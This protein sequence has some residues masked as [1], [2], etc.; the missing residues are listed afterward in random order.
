MEGVIA[1]LRLEPM[2]PLPLVALV[3]GLAGGLGALYLAQ[4]IF[5]LA[6][7]N[8][9]PA[10]VKSAGAFWLVGV[11]ALPPMALAGAALAAFRPLI[12]GFLLTAAAIM[13]PALLGQNPVAGWSAGLIAAAGIAAFLGDGLTDG[14]G[15]L[16][17][18]PYWLLMILF[19]LVFTL[20]TRL[21]I[22]NE[23]F[24]F[25]GYVVLE[26]VVL[27]TAWNI[28][29]GYTGYTNFGTAAFFALGAY[30][31]VVLHK[32]PA[33]LHGFGWT[34]PPVPLPVMMLAG[35]VVSGV[36]GL[37]MG[38]LTLRLRGVFFAIATLAL[39]I[40]AQT[41]IVN[42][43]FVGGSRGIYII[44]PALAP[45]SG[46]YIQY[47]FSLMTLLSVVS[48]GIA[49]S[50]E[51]SHLGLGLHS[52]RDDE[53]AAEASGVPT[54]KLKLI[55]TT[56]SGALMGMAGAPLP[57]YVTYLDPPSS[58]NLSYAVNSVAMPVIGGMTSWIGPVIGSILLGT[59]QQLATVMISSAANLLIVG[60]LLIAFVT[61]AP[62]GLIGLPR[63][64]PFLFA[65]RGRVSLRQFWLWFILPLLGI[66][67]AVDLAGMAVQ[68]FL[69]QI[70][71]LV[72]G[73]LFSIAA[74]WPML[75]VSAKRCHDR[76]RSAWFLLVALIPVAGTL[77]LLVDLYCLRGE[78][79]TNAYG[80]PPDARVPGLAQAA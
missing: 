77:W 39:A 80:P 32:L 22:A 57:Y 25:A 69:P 21:A 16:K 79:G 61:L 19:G 35:G 44:R 42:W 9:V 20:S 74:L 49:R 48:V 27:S 72:F 71:G 56:L 41:L 31:A 43:D 18:G 58:F 34:I 70:P 14:E 66:T 76:G 78:A 36:I 63:Q 52:I 68:L 24:Y 5:F 67:L 33:L 8:T 3:L 11:A 53:L 37:G 50:I 51:R 2:R 65:V 73:E 62:N 46:G 59:I 4:A 12:A 64:H 10:A 1:K 40:V 55:S 17:G 75:A 13:T 26:Y 30:S 47:L 23:Y 38:Y 28:L 7:D 54:L 6:G 15:T 45:I 60:L 29:G